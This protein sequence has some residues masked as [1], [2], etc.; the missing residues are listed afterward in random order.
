MGTEA[1]AAS[2]I[3]IEPMSLLMPQTFT[4]DHPFLFVLAKSDTLLFVGTY[5]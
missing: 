3:M 4:A 2:G 1:A 5:I